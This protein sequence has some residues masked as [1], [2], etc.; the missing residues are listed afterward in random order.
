MQRIKVVGNFLQFTNILSL[1]KYV[2]YYASYSKINI[3]RTKRRQKAHLGV[4]GLKKNA[5]PK[6]FL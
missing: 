3:T 1:S 2:L 4:K 6:A 5:T